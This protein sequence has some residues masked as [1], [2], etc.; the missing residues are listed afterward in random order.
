MNLRRVINQFG[1]LLVV[2]SLTM[3]GMSVVFFLVE[4]VL[5]NDVE[6]AARAALFASGLAGTLAGGF[7]WRIT[8]ATP[9]YL[10][11]REAL[12]LVS[13][14]W[15]I[16]AAFAGL[17]FFLWAHMPETGAPPDHPFRNFVD[18]YFEAMSGLTT[19]GASVLSNI[20]A[21]PRSLLL[22]RAFTQWIGGAGLVVLFVAVLPSLGVGG[23]RLFM[24]E[25]SGPAPEGLQP[26]I[27]QTARMLLYIYVGLNAVQIVAL[28]AAGMSLFDSICTALATVA[29]GGFGARTASLAEYGLAVQVITIVFMVI[30]GVNFGLYF[31]L[32]RRRYDTVLRDTELRVYI[33]L[34]A[35]GALVVALSLLH[36]PIVLADG[37]TLEASPG[38]AVRHGLFTVVSLG[39]TTGFVTADYNSWPFIALAVIILIMFIGGSAG[40]T[41]GGIKVIRLWIALK[42]MYCEVERAFRPNVVRPVR[43]GTS[44]VDAQLRLETLVYVLGFVLLCAAG[45]VALMLIEGMGEPGACDFT[46]ASTA[47]VSCMSSIGPGLGKVGAVGNY[48][49]MTPYGKALLS[50]LMVLGRLE[51]FPIIVLLAPRFWVGDR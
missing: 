1:L 5:G 14:S 41:A 23:K 48:G 9:L 30:G 31:A 19:T 39:T 29:T 22:W 46:T 37:E 12:L 35:C 38:N 3:L 45:S 7:L 43:V 6:P 8:G 13:L 2:L 44:V 34:L 49:W 25:V 21:V 42:I 17:P 32:L 4:A 11:R 27:H 15:L 16:G 36:S 24:A 26:Q 40:S 47:V 20:E 18:C 50:L 33:L 51:I 10:G 28:C